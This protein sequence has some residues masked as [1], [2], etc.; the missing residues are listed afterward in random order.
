[1]A[2]KASGHQQAAADDDDEH[3]WLQKI[4]LV[5]RDKSPAADHTSVYQPCKLGTKACSN[6]YHPS[7]HLSQ[8]KVTQLIV[9]LRSGSI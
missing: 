1:M 8:P 2:R 3:G 9:R 6:L 4:T 7:S 5:L